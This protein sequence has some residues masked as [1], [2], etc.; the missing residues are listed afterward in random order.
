MNEKDVEDSEQYKRSNQTT[1]LGKDFITEYVIRILLTKS[2]CIAGN[3]EKYDQLMDLICSLGVC[4]KD[5]SITEVYSIFQ[6]VEREKLDLKSAEINDKYKIHN[7]TEEEAEKHPEFDAIVREFDDISLFKSY[8]Y[9]EKDIKAVDIRRLYSEAEYEVV[10]EVCKA[11]VTFP[12]IFIR[13]VEGK[14]DIFYM[15]FDHDKKRLCTFEM[16]LYKYLFDGS[17]QKMFV[18]IM[19]GVLEKLKD[20]SLVTLY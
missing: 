13:K 7:I 11:N 1:F 16:S 2:I 9:S 19:I 3:L 15:K 18:D 17:E 12:F 14:T 6:L 4:M 8:G 10:E 20:N 5:K